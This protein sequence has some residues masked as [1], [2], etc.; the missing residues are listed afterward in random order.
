MNRPCPIKCDV[1]RDSDHH[2]IDEIDETGEP[3]LACKRC[4]ATKPW[5]DEDDGAS[6]TGGG[7]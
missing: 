2:W 7:E 3:I 4:D 5:E 6:A 1:C